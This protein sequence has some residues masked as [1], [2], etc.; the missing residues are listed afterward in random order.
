MKL[1][2]TQSYLCTLYERCVDE[3]MDVEA[4]RLY[5]L[6]EGIRKT[7]AMIVDDLEHTFGFLGYAESHP[8]PAKPDAARIDALIAREHHNGNRKFGR[9]EAVSGLS[10]N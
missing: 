10:R 5:L 2:T 3:D 8:A 7:P 4:I 6:D 1:T 9:Y